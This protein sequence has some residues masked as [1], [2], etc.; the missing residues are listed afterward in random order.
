MQKEERV[1]KIFHIIFAAFCMGNLFAQGSAKQN[2]VTVEITQVKSTEGK[3]YLCIFDSAQGYDKKISYREL[4]LNPKIGTVVFET[5][6]PDGDYVFSL[7]QDTNGN[8]RLDTGFMGIPKEPIALSNY[9]GKGIPGKFKKHKIS[10]SADTKVTVR[11]IE[12]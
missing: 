8:G 5:S 9:D 4:S 1:K 10:I 6:L 3:I 7:C 2:K 11:M 12:F